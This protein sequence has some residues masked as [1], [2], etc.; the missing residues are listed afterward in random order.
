MF[1]YGVKLNLMTV[2]QYDIC[3]VLVLQKT[4]KKQYIYLFNTKGKAEVRYRFL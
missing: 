4:E 2:P 1:F 3:S